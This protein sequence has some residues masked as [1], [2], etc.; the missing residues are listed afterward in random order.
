M[1]RRPTALASLLPGGAFVASLALSAL[2]NGVG[3]QQIKP[4]SLIT[5]AEAA[6]IL[7]KPA[8]A[9]AQS[10]PSGK[11]T[12]AYAGA[13]FDVRAEE[14]E[15]PAV[16]SATLHEMIEEK[17]AEAIRGIGDE[18]AFAVDGNRD[19]A[20]M[21]RRGPRLITVTMYKDQ[22]TLEDAKPVLLKLLSLAMS[23]VR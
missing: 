3:A 15:S 17:R 23:K 5:K 12:C 4:C 14:L 6:R 21:S 18:A 19:F 2:E 11:D 22:S 10:V 1:V 16:W 20:M 7:A 9:K 13:G 8:I